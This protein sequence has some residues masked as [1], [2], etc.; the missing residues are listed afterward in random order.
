[1]VPPNN[2]RILPYLDC[3]TFSFVR[4]YRSCIHHDVSSDFSVLFYLAFLCKLFFHP[5]HVSQV[6][7]SCADSLWHNS[8]HQGH[9]LSKTEHLESSSNL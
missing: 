6:P 9:F 3:Q 5:V 2:L 1:M 8:H 4:T 7:R